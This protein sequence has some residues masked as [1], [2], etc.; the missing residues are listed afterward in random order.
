MEA[1]QKALQGIYKA[2]KDK[3]LRKIIE[4]TDTHNKNCLSNVV[5]VAKQMFLTDSD[6][7]KAIELMCD[8]FDA[9][10]SE[11][12]PLAI[13]SIKSVMFN[14][15]FP[16]SLKL[17]QYLVKNPNTMKYDLMIVSFA[18]LSQGFYEPENRTLVKDELI[19]TFCDLC[20]QALKSSIKQVVQEFL[21][22]SVNNTSEF[23][24]QQISLRPLSPVIV[25]HVVNTLLE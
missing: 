8:V 7:I 15:E 2:S 23:M 18:R 21:L 19:L 12:S 24:L 22:H 1:I 6:L 4:N 5:Q 10:E 13:Q 9:L 25:I 20:E 14:S 17:I 16:I 3:Q 11:Y